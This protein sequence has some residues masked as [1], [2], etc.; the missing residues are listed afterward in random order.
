VGFPFDPDALLSMPLMANLAT[1]SDDGPRN[2]PVWF[3]WENG[4]LWMLGNDGSSSVRRLAKDARCAVEIVH[5]DNA[6]G[7]L[8]HLGLRG[9][10]TVET[11]DPPRFRRLLAKYL[12]PNEE[13]WNTW[14]LAR[15]ARIDDPDGRLIRLDPASV[16]TNN[17]SHFRTGPDLAWPE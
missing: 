3:L 16:F 12:G 8:A 10:A 14:F 17:V 13:R 11:M 2:A 5:Y 6:R 7:I 9:R 1:V 4:A 15:V